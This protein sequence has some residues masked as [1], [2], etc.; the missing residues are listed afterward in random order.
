LANS[1]QGAALVE[2][3]NNVSAL[4]GATANSIVF[5]LSYLHA[6]WPPPR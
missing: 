2:L 4:H 5:M 3:G 6:M 1:G